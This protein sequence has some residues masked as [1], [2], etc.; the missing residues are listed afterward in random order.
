MIIKKALFIIKDI[1]GINRPVFYSLL[2]KIWAF[3][4]TPITFWLITTKFSPDVQGYYYTFNSLLVFQNVLEVGFGVV[5]VQFISHEWACIKLDTTN[6]ITADPS[7]LARLASIIKLGFK[8]YI[9]LSLLFLVVVGT[10]GYLFLS[11][12]KVGI[13]FQKPWWLLCAAVSI[14]I[15]LTPIRC[16]LEGSNKIDVLQQ[17]YLKASMVSNIAGW[18]SIYLGAELYSA[19]IISSISAIVRLLLFIP[20]FMPFYKILK[21]NIRLPGISWKNEFWPQQWRTGISWL[22][23]FFMFNSLVPIMFQLH[24]PIIA[25]QMGL[26][27]Q[28]YTGIDSFAQCWITATGPK[29]GIL[30]AKKD[31]KGLKT[32]VK[33]TYLRSLIA[34]ICLAV[35][36]FVIIYLLNLYNIP[37]V[38]RFAD[39]F[40]IV[41][42]LIALTAMQLPNVEAT[43]VRFQKKEP[44]VIVS[45]LSAFMVF[46]LSILCGNIWGIRG[47][48]IAFTAVI[49]LF[50]IP[51]FHK[52]YKNEIGAAII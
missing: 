30:A 38:K 24:G 21:T 28:I 17:V 46:F 6:N 29:M 14:S 25:G 1:F 33:H 2:Y 16:F 19:S 13:D 41:I 26:T 52:I 11:Q 7:T 42:L 4:F 40:S 51:M 9:L 27:M 49:V 43:A 23:S 12:Y 8:W 31:I 44:F 50:L 10:G 20:A 36:V 32:L 37:Q 48:V 47:A 45:I 39:L 22:S 3:A 34:C 18:L 5:M 35:T 15:I